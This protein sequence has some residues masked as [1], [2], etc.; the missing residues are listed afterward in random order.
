MQG[1][2]L[3]FYPERRYGFLQDTE[4][5]VD[6]FFHRGDVLEEKVPHTGAL[7]SFELTEYNG[8]KKAINIRTVTAT[9]VLSGGAL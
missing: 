9:E 5:G 1:N 7:V 8:R 6:Y 2:I 4:T 3:K